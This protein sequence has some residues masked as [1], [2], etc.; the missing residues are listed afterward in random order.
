MQQF[1]F[2]IFSLIAVVGTILMY[3]PQSTFLDDGTVWCC[4]YDQHYHNCYSGNPGC[5]L[6]PAIEF[7]MEGSAVSATRMVKCHD[8][9]QCP[10][11]FEAGYFLS[12]FR[13]NCPEC[14]TETNVNSTRQWW[15][16]A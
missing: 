8:K 16:T 11:L 3:Q 12:G 9:L 14:T 1:L 2:G 6:G 15:M 7:M 5:T 4:Y 10:A 13:P